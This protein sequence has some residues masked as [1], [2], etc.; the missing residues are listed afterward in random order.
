MR[1]SKNGMTTLALAGE[2]V[3]RSL[4]IQTRSGR[5]VISIVLADGQTHSVPV[6]FYPTLARATPAQAR[7]YRPIGRGLGF[8]WPDLD[9]DLSVRGLLEGRREVVQSARSRRLAG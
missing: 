9:L 1:S 8:H 3:A 7:R 2:P 5:R 6:S 4:R